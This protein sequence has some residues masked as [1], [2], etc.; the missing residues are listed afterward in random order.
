MRYLSHFEATIAKPVAERRE[1]DA[2]AAGEPATC[3][4]ETK[5]LLSGTA[6]KIQGYRRRAVFDQKLQTQAACSGARVVGFENFLTRGRSY[7][8]KQ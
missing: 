7:L 1:L 6:E 5:R 2:D 4:L 3:S 8:C